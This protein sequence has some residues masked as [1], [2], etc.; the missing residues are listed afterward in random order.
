M[1]SEDATSNYYKN[2]M[3]LNL[4]NQW[5]QW[6]WT[7]KNITFIM[8]VEI[9]PRRYIL[10]LKRSIMYKK[11]KNK[12][13]EVDKITFFFLKKL[14]RWCSRTSLTLNQFAIIKAPKMSSRHLMEKLNLRWEYYY[15]S[16]AHK[17]HQKHLSDSNIPMG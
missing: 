8:G 10:R 7:E 13:N 11:Q 6:K 15:R 4:S 17:P 5:K 3:E 2:R 16:M 9:S 12:N 14:S 1:Y